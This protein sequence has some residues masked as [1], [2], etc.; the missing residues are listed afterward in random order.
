MSSRFLTPRRLALLTG[1]AAGLGSTAYVLIPPKPPPIPRFKKPEDAFGADWA[2]KRKEREGREEVLR[3][4]GKPT[5]SSCSSKPLTA[6][7]LEK[8]ESNPTFDILIIGGG[9]TG[10]GVALDAVTRQMDGDGRLRVGL[11]ERGDFGCGTSSKS[12]KLV[13]GGVRYLQKAVMEADWEQWKLVREA[14]AERATF[15]HIAPYLSGMLPIMLPVYKYH[16]LPYYFAGCKLYD[17]L[18]GKEGMGGSW[19]CG[20]ATALASFPNLKKEGLVGGVVYQDGQH[21]DARM[22]IAILMTAREKGARVGNYIEVTQIHKSPTTGQIIGA[23][24]KDRDSWGTGEEWDVG[25]KCI[26]NATG[27]FCDAVMDMAVDGVVM[28]SSALGSSS[29]AKPLTHM[30]IVRPSSGV[31]I[32]LDGRFARQPGDSTTPSHSLGMGL[33]DPSTSDG[34]VIF[35]LPWEGGVVAGTT[36]VGVEIPGPES[37]D[38]VINATSTLPSLADLQEPHPLESEIMWILGEVRKYV[39]VEVRREDVKAAWSGLRPLVLSPGSKD[40]QSLVRS[41]LITRGPTGLVTI[42]GGKWTTYRRM[43]EE[44]VDYLLKNFPSLM[45]V[46]GNTSLTASGGTSLTASGAKKSKKDIPPS[47]TASIPLI[48][49]EGWGLGLGE[50]LRER[51]GFSYKTADHLCRAYGDRAWV[52]AEISEELRREAGQTGSHELI[53][54]SHPHLL[55]E[56]VYSARYEMARGGLDVLAR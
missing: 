56:V 55:A 30:P 12:T 10:S 23:R 35:V 37:K 9:A 32:V 16:Q 52:V 13:H 28:P 4:L 54:P 1:F 47:L 17:V 3:G 42:V 40:T 29:S 39:D 25:A 41:H 53:H 15:L 33:L 50:A 43:A 19:V 31:H 36:D 38:L 34:R 6:Q 49:T 26:V 27:P 24:L 45:E 22:N 7:E 14:L 2:E 11:V 51:Y 21:N 5:A 18:A 46:S 8:L 20:R 48:G 44:G